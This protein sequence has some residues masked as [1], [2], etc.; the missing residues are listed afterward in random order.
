MS[1]TFIITN[2]SIIFLTCISC[3]DIN[4]A[5]SYP[6]PML[7]VRDMSTDEVINTYPTAGMTSNT[8]GT[9]MNGGTE[10]GVDGGSLA[11]TIAGE[12]VMAGT[13]AGM[14]SG[15]GQ[16][17]SIYGGMEAG[18]DLG[19]VEGGTNGGS[20]MSGQLS[21][22]GILQCMDICEAE[23]DLC[24]Q[25]CFDQGS[26]E[27]IIALNELIDCDI[28]QGCQANVDCLIASCSTEVTRCEQGSGVNMGGT[29]AGMEAGNTGGMTGGSQPLPEGPLSC[30]ET[31]DCL[32]L[33]DEA[34]NSCI[35]YCLD[36]ATPSAI[37]AFSNLLACNETNMCSDSPNP[38]CI[39][40]NCSD[41]L[42]ACI[43]DG[44]TDP[45]P[46]PECVIDMDCGSNYTCTQ[47]ACEAISC[48]DDMYEP[49]NSIMDATST[50]LTAL[51]SSEEELTICGNDEDYYAVSVCG[52]GAVT[53]TVTFDGELIDIDIA[54]TLPN[55]LFDEEV[56]QDATAS[57]EEVTYENLAPVDQTIYLRVDQFSL[58]SD[59]ANASY[60]LDLSFNCP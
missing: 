41:E 53:A 54:F 25:A 52:F 37:I 42:E 31:F 34:D 24:V 44:Q 36:L 45:V 56:S 32:E 47:N 10:G 49:N 27:G 13:T 22:I 14:S 11:G 20:M 46:V 3:E 28:R 2:L 59:P 30:S 9:T 29:E 4:E 33:C 21:C 17:G 19:G 39:P 50:T 48:S 38:D 58:F 35:Q 23:D 15:G 16:A 18:S 1:K 8:A 7:R 12:S 40:L 5:P 57:V 26:P 60:T 51:I 55:S 6:E 43:D